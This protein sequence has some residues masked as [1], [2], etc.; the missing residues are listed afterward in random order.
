MQFSAF[1]PPATNSN[2]SPMPPARAIIES[3]RRS[4]IWR[5]VVNRRPVIVGR[6]SI[7]HRRIGAWIGGGG[8][9]HVEVDPLGDMV[10]R[11]EQVPCLEHP[12]LG[13]LV[14]GQR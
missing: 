11:G 3:E 6:R 1:G 4:P 12:D 14:G 9:V 13:K 2:L 8:M 5:P 10:L 7:D